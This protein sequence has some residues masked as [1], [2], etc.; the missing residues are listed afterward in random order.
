MTAGFRN[1]L[2][3]AGIGSLAF[4]ALAPL[5]TLAAPGITLQGSF[6]GTNGDSPQVT[7]TAAGNGIYYGTTNTGGANGSGA[8]FKFDSATG[9]ITLQDSF[10]FSNGDTP[11]AALTS[12]GNGIY[13]GTTYQGGA[14]FSGTIY[15]FDSAT[16]S[17][18]LQA[19]FTGS[20][21]SA[22]NAALTAAGNGIYYGTTRFGG[23]NSAGGIFKFDSAT[24]SITLQDSFARESLG[25]RGLNSR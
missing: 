1:N 16:G 11:V 5:P 15:S 12:A 19:S 7:L 4:S 9:S 6:T 20:N 8:I 25:N 2:V 24:G 13:Y 21:G 14:N 17:I 10:N 22:P 23:A 3:L 18:T